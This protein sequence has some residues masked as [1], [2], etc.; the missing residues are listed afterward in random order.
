MYL[1]ILIVF[2]YVIDHKLILLYHTYVL[3]DWYLN[4]SYY[5]NYACHDANNVYFGL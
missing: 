5:L 2:T 4:S 1:K 3:H